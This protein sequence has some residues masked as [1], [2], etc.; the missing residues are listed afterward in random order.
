[1]NIELLKRILTFIILCLVQALVLNHIC[2]FG[3]AT[4]LLYVYLVMTFRRNQPKWSLLL[5]CFAMGLIMD[6][7][8]NTPGVASASMTLVGL[9]QPYILG[10]FIQRDSPDDLEPSIKSIGLTSYLY[11]SIIIVLLYCL[12]FFTLEAFSFFNWL[13]WIECI[14][15]STLLTVILILVIDNIK[16]R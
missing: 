8:S 4:P 3:C 15:G 12:T 7:F 11:F 16:K 5:W 10:M 14:G 1:M 13:Q 9:L 6:M 2:L